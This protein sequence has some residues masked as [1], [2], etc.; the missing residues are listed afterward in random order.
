MDEIS[1][2]SAGC[3]WG[4]KQIF[5]LAQNR[6]FLEMDSEFSI[7]VNQGEP[8]PG[9]K[10]MKDWCTFPL[11]GHAGRDSKLKP[12]MVYDTKKPSAHK[13][14]TKNTCQ[15]TREPARKDRL[16]DHCLKNVFPTCW[17]WNWR[18][19][20]ERQNLPLQASSA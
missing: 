2:N 15:F 20:C 4:G 1:F 11:K 7:Y 17:I 9:L 18:L 6:S 5:W 8:A 12:L 3:H 14:Y 10:A 19:M 16:L 13:S